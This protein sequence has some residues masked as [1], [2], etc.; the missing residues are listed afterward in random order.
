MYL[1]RTPI[2]RFKI[3]MGSYLLLIAT[4]DKAKSDQDDQATFAPVR[5]P[6]FIG[7]NADES[8]DVTLV[9]ESEIP[10][11]FVQIPAGKAVCQGDRED[12]YSGPREIRETDDSFLAEFPVTC[13]EYL[14]FLNDRSAMGEE[15]AARRVPRASENAG[16]Y[17]LRGEDG[18]FAI[19]TAAWLAQTGEA[20]QAS[21]RRLA[22]CPFDWEADW[23]VLSVSW[24]DAVTYAAWFSRRHGLLAALPH[25]VMWEKAARG[26]DARVYPFG[27][28]FDETY[29]NVS[30][31]H[32][33]PARPC[34]VR[35]FPPDESPYG[36]RGLCGNSADWCFADGPE[37]LRQPVR[38]GAWLGNRLRA[39]ASHRG[40]N[41]RTYVFE[42]NG[43]RLAV[44]PRASGADPRGP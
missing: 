20:G 27:A 18:R 19:P 34:P 15:E 26:T 3:P 25:E 16:F 38:G 13:A 24:E 44:L 42:G 39:R 36:A 41:P 6:V 14:E 35:S 10:A 29:A 21:L 11:G 33:G 8:V 7:R 31:S 2:P 23:P 12:P 30:R 28:H 40:G 32:D 17:W 43:F 5:V 22:Q 9:R 37:S 4:E 1:G